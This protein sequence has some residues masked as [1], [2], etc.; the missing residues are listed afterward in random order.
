MKKN[1]PG[2]LL[3]LA[4]VIIFHLLF[5][6]GDQ[7]FSGAFEPGLR[8]L[9]FSL[10]FISYWMLFWELSRLI[11]RR[12]TGQAGMKKAWYRRLSI[13]S[14]ILFLSVIAG[15]VL[16]SWGYEILNNFFGISPGNDVPLINPEIF[17]TPGHVI[18]TNLN[19][20]LL[21][22]IILFFFLIYGVHLFISSFNNAKEMELLAA[23]REKENIIA[24][25]AALKNQ[26]D[27]H[28]FFNSLS[29]L[30]SLIYENTD[31]SAEFISHLSKHYRYILET[32]STNLVSLSRELD[33]LDSYFYLMNIRYP[34]SIVKVC[35]ISEQTRSECMM[36]PHSLLMLVENAIKHNMFSREDPFSIEITE[37]E[38]Y[39]VVRNR[40]NRRKVIRESTGI[41][42][43]NI[44]KRYRIEC[45]KEVLIEDSGNLFSVKLPKI[46]EK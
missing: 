6:Q 19:F 42:L 46:L 34:D 17:D 9:T 45:K 40:I 43:E 31:L 4:V 36:L 35:E 33:N 11:F 27:P 14:L 29:V 8:S 16:F 12:M 28:F 25:Y 3:R 37:E 13:V 44:I 21:F 2:F 32:E 1:N 41:G 10:F 22:G 26:I 24:Q 20:E 30:S 18:F 7:S 5:K 39:I 38:E 23:E 15:A